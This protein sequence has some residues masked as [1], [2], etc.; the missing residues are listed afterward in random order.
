MNSKRMFQEVTWFGHCQHT[1]INK[2]KIMDKLFFLKI[3]CSSHVGPNGG[4]RKVT[5]GGG[6]CHH[7]DV[8]VHE[9]MH[10][11]GKSICFPVIAC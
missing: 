5:L 8:I 6:G 2:T 1:V 4:V 9:V 11:L 10:A 3:S 7:R